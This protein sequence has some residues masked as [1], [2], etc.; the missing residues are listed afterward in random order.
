MLVLRR[1]EIG[2]GDQ[3]PELAAAILRVRNFSRTFDQQLSFALRRDLDPDRI[4]AAVNQVRL[5]RL[6]TTKPERQ[7]V[8]RGARLARESR[9]D[10]SHRRVG[11]EDGDL[12]VEDRPRR[13][14]DIRPVV[15]E[16]NHLEHRGE[17]LGG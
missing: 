15:L 4:D 11:A 8:V 17:R 12:V 16:V 10:D 9:D 3:E 14:A 2:I 1:R 7:V 6:G 5:G 13:V